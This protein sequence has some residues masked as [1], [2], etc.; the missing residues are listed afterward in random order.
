MSVEGF[1]MFN[2]AN[3]K[4]RIVLTFFGDIL[5]VIQDGNDTNHILG[6]GVIQVVFYVRIIEMPYSCSIILN[7][8]HE[9]RVVVSSKVRMA[10]ISSSG[11]SGRIGVDV[12]I[13][14][15]IV[16]VPNGEGPPNFYDDTFNST[17]VHFRNRKMSIVLVGLV[18]IYDIVVTDISDFNTDFFLCIFI[19]RCNVNPFLIHILTVIPI[20]KT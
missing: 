6:N 15:T 10:S 11:I 16:D 8:F 13:I 3:N 9:V 14:S 20:R 1:G 4:V 2:V 19:I 17:V 7:I 5:F 18:G 12:R